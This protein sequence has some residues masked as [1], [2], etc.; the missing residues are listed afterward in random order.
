MHFCKVSYERKT[1]TENNSNQYTNISFKCFLNG[2]LLK[3]MENIV[4][5]SNVVSRVLTLLDE[6]KASIFNVGSFDLFLLAFGW[7]LNV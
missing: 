3:E 6:V 5:Q 1:K 4:W 7:E 2:N